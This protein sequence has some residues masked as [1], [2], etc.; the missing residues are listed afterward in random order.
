[1]RQI[2]DQQIQAD[3]S[4]PET[5]IPRRISGDFFTDPVPGLDTAWNAFIIP[6][7]AART[8]RKEQTGLKL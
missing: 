1:M 5:R 8:A 2:E 3:G 7:S 6:V 4:L